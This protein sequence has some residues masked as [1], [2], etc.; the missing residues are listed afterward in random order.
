M[1]RYGL[2]LN[3]APLN[4]STWPIAIKD[5]GDF[6]YWV[7][8]QAVEFLAEIGRHDGEGYAVDRFLV[9]I[10]PRDGYPLSDA[11]ALTI[12]VL[13]RVQQHAWW[14]PSGRSKHYLRN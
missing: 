9:D 2:K 13:R 3:A 11:A 4:R 8:R 5:T 6:G 7:D 14:R 12:E 1:Q 10:D